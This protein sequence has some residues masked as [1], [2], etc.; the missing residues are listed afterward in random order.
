M[1][2]TFHRLRFHFEAT[3]TV[4]FPA[5]KPGNVLRGAF[6]LLFRKL[7][8]VPECESA[9]HC[10]MQQECPYSRV[11]EPRPGGAPSGLADAPR[12]FVFRASHLDGQTVPPLSPFH[13]DVNLFEE[14]PVSIPF[15]VL[16][17]QRLALDGLGPRRGKAVLR[18]VELLDRDGVA[19][20]VLF[21]GV[22]L[23]EELHPVVIDLGQPEFAQS[24]TVRFLTPTELKAAHAL[25]QRPEFGVLMARIRDR[26]STLRALYGAGPLELDFRRFAAEAELVEMTHC[27]IRH[28]EIERTSRRTGQTHPLGGFVGSARYRGDLGSFVP[29]LR[30]ACFTGVGRQTVWGKGEITVS[31]E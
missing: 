1:L 25:A 16:A 13:F 30:A 3:G 29:F 7:T 26:I 19:R 6:G 22:R 4:F 23:R 24:L 5:G 17:F 28:V 20:G 11:F 27:E 8:C 18:R 2:F 31:L 10:P 9:R 21:D 14:S 15:F 12:P